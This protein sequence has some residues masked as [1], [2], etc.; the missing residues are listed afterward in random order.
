L[1]IARW[2][3]AVVPL[4]LAAAA[5]GQERL[6][7]GVLE[8]DI[9]GGLGLILGSQRTVSCTFTPATPGPIEF[10]TG[11]ISKI[12][13]DIGITSAGLME[14]AVYGPS[15]GP[16]GALAGIYAGAGAEAS[17]VTG[18]GANALVGGSGGIVVLQPLSVQGQLGVNIAAGVS[19]LE[20]RFMR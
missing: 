14:W 19:E 18:V 10:Y 16:G 7:A 3:F 20:L 8:C 15:S 11:T 2:L 1:R 17:L 12:G 5:P 6:Q 9:S 13:L 4:L